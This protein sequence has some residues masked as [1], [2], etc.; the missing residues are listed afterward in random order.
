MQLYRA[1]VSALECVKQ[2]LQLESELDYSLKRDTT[3]RRLCSGKGRREMRNP[4]EVRKLKQLIP[5]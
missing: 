5:R 4:E 1:A 2:S 3:R